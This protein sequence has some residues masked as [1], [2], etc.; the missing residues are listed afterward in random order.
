MKQI[1]MYYRK[2]PMHT[3]NFIDLPKDIMYF[4]CFLSLSDW[5]DRLTHWWSSRIFT[6]HFICRL[7][8]AANRMAGV[9]IYVKEVPQG[10][11]YFEMKSE[12]TMKVVSHVAEVID[13]KLCKLYGDKVFIDFCGGLLLGFFQSEQCWSLTILKWNPGALPATV[14]KCSAN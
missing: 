5:K 3:N 11:Y 13:L 12:M 7:S 4:K 1:V 8:L 6:L 10:Y 9:Y 2:I 14:I